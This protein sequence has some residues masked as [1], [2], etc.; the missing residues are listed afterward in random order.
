[1]DKLAPVTSAAAE[2]KSLFS[3]FGSSLESTFNAQVQFRE[4]KDYGG[5]GSMFVLVC[6][7]TRVF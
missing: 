4:D 3:Q 1:M 5:L 2:T 6:V 7:S